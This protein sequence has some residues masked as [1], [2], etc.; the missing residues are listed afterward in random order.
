MKII[1]I[2]IPLSERT[3]VWEGDKGISINLVAKIGEG[4]DFNVSRIELGV[5]AGTH[6]DSPFHLLD[7]G[8]TVDQ[9]PLET[10]IGKVQVVQVPLDYDVINEKC[11][12]AID[13]DPTVDRILFKT[14]NSN[15]WE[16]DPYAFNKEF[17]ALNTDGAQ[18]LENLGI[19]LV[20]VD[21]FSVSAY[22]DL[23]LPH[24]ILLEHGIVLLENIDLRNVAPGFYTLVC[25]QIKLIG[26]DGAPVRAVLMTE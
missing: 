5:H 24:V 17:V 3:P 4:S 11:L 18:Y 15:Y 8:N 9:I 1:D 21:Y 12:E 25:L 10:L 14:S 6:I 22:D 23:K 26:T 19:R 7:G 13:L 2:T 16:K 20:G